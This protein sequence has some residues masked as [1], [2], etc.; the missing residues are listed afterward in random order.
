MKNILITGGD[1]QL[2]SALKLASIGFSDFNLVFTDIAEFDI[3]NQDSVNNFLKENQFDF[4]INCA[5][6]TAVD[7]AEE[8][9]ELAYRINALGPKNLAQACKAYSCRLIH[10]STDYVFD[11]KNF[12]PYKEEME[13]NPPSIYGQSK[14]EG[15]QEICRNNESAIIIRTSWLYSEFGNNFLKTIL[16]LGAERDEL[17]V[18]FD[19]IG[20]PTYAVDLAKMLLILIDKNLPFEK[21]EIF[22]YSNEGVISWYDFAREIMDLAQLKCQIV[23]IESWEYP[24]PAPRPYYSVLNKRKIKTTYKLAIPYWKDSLHNCMKNLGYSVSV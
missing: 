1:G 20:T 5:A 16:K 10:I 8:Q 9:K 22:H 7:K 15:E 3:T 23:P 13:C 11:G 4:L 24:L 19:Q 18:I 14:L 21:S 17:R 2:G 12:V 6:Y